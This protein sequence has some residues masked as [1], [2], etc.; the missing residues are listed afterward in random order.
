[1]RGFLF[2]GQGVMDKMN[3]TNKPTKKVVGWRLPTDLIETVQSI[4]ERDGRHIER[5]AADALRAGLPRTDDEAQR[6]AKVSH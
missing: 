2:A 5:V 6:R 4:A 3:R 1:M